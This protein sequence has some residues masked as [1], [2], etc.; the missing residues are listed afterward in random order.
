MARPA[1]PRGGPRQGLRSALPSAEG[2]GGTIQRPLGPPSA[3][4]R[5]PYEL[6]GP[7][8]P[9]GRIDEL[10]FADLERRGLAPAPLA[11]DGVFLR[12]VWLDLAGRLPAPEEARAFLDDRDPK[13]RGA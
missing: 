1:A 3:R 2:A 8:T 6:P 11:S 4:G 10:V 7:P 9:R 12:R 13:K 5:E